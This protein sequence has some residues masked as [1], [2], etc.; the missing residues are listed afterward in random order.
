[1]EIGWKGFSFKTL[2]LLLL[3][4]FIAVILSLFFL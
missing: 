2:Y 3:L 1:M 4:I